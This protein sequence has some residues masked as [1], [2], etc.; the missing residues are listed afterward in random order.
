VT[1]QVTQKLAGM[2][3]KLFYFMCE[4]SGFYMRNIL[5]LRIRHITPGSL[6]IE[7]P[8]DDRFAGDSDGNMLHSGL[9]ASVIDH[10]GGFCAWSALTDTKQSVSTID[11]QVDYLSPAKLNEPLICEANIVHKGGMV[12][13]TDMICWNES[14]TIKIASGRG[15]YN[16]YTNPLMKKAGLANTFN[17]TLQALPGEYSTRLLKVVID[18]VTWIRGVKSQGKASRQAGELVVS[19]E[20][21]K[22]HEI[23]RDSSLSI[24]NEKTIRILERYCSFSQ[25]VLGVRVA[26]ASPDR[27]I[28]TLPFKRDFIGN[29]SLPCL[30]GGVTAAFLDH[31]GACAAWLSFTAESNTTCDQLNDRE[32]MQDNEGKIIN[33]SSEID[34]KRQTTSVD[35]RIDYVKPALC[36]E[37]ICDAEVVHRG[38]ML[39]RVNMTCYNSTRTVKVALGRGLYRVQ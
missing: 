15:L 9:T 22:F 7:L 28:M 8:P 10:A 12:I 18:W 5:H 33:D 34:I 17:E 13:R 21:A 32:V 11:L 38:S 36:E 14:K 31:C 2:E 4:A 37:L 24:T 23:P 6:T 16:I 29:P 19:D 30:H 3:P 25:D 35:F 27:L 20:T 39:V 1:P 26:F